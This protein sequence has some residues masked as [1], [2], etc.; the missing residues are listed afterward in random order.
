M[1]RERGHEIC[2]R[3]IPNDWDNALPVGN[4]RL[5]AMVFRQG[6]VLHIALNHYDCYYQVLPGL[7]KEPGQ[8]GQT[9]QD[10]A[11]MTETY[12]ELCRRADAA[13]ERGDTAYSHYVRTL[14]PNRGTGRPSYRG[15][16]YPPGGEVLLEMSGTVDTGHSC[17]KLRIEEAAVTLEAGNGA[18][19]VAARIWAARDRDGIVVELFQSQG[20]LWK[21]IR[22]TSPPVVGMPPGRSEYRRMRHGLCMRTFYARKENGDADILQEAALCVR[23]RER[24]SGC[25]GESGEN[26]ADDFIPFTDAGTSMTAVVSL[27]P[28][29]GNAER[30]AEKLAGEAGQA[31]LRHQAFWERFWVS[32]VHLPDAFLE[33]L[34]YLQLY[35]MECSCGRGSAWPEQACGLSGLWDIRRPNMW[36]SMWY[37]D[38][39]IQSAFW[40]WGSAGHPEFLKLFCDGYLA[41][42]PEIRAYTEKVYGVKGWALDY[43]HTLYHCIQPWCAQF[44]WQ[45][46]QYSQD[47]GFLREKAYP[48]FREQVVFFRWLSETDGQGIRHIRYDISPEQGPVTEDSVITISC[49]RRLLQMAEEA[50]KILDRSVEELE[51]YRRL[52]REL[53]PYPLA[54]DGNRY[55][56]S[57]LVQDSVFLRHP[58]MLMPLFP[59]E[60]KGVE[61]K[62]KLWENT[63]Q[64]AVGHTETGTFGMGWLAAAAAKLG[65]GRTALRLLYEKGLDYALHNNGLI[66]E[67]SE[68]F[69]NYCH[70]TKPSHFLPVMMEAAGGLANTVNLML[71]QTGEE[72]ELRIFPAVPDET[73]D[74]PERILQYHEDI[75]EAERVY[76]SWKDVSFSGLMAPGGFRVWAERRGGRTIYLKVESRFEAVLKLLLPEELAGEEQTLWEGRQA[77]PVEV[78]SSG[79][80]G[81]AE[82]VE[83]RSSG[84]GR[85]TEPVEV[86]RR[87]AEYRMKPGE[88]RCWGKNTASTPARNVASCHGQENREGAKAPGPDGEVLCHVAAGTRRRVFLGGDRHTAYFQAIDAFTCAYLLANEH[89][90]PRTP[91]VF[92]FGTGMAEKEYADAYP[93]QF[94]VSGQCVLYAAGPKSV[95]ICTYDQETGYGFLGTEGISDVD[96]GEPDALRRDFLEGRGQA[97]FALYL[98]KGKYDIL[99]ICGDEREASCTRVVLPG[100]GTAECTGKLEAGRFGC[101]V[102]PLVHRQDG[103]LRIGISTEEGYR[104]KLNAMF[105]NQ[106][107]VLSG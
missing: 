18:A 76:D 41:Y 103:M 44:L 30:E 34:W 22:L 43:P 49:I 83:V 1:E 66:Y 3:D 90:Y 35:L 68:R 91:Y 84:K 50:G 88:V 92:D 13:R 65:R 5:G 71:L 69:L 78:R 60:E 80:G 99:L 102:L 21:G 75:G 97:V 96:R 87:V 48:V 9:F 31:R 95:G 10:P 4:G 74:I 40:G 67:E 61:E 25:I 93:M 70:L 16:C 100:N 17:L 86:K 105:V 8:G 47:M 63:L 6:S 32:G 39:N 77:E 94:A 27:Q 15:V 7:N 59:A 23:E 2:F 57:R 38:V 62:R 55:K 14:H 45:Y 101:L 104:W 107:Y 24:I 106:E 72:G 28:G 53:P 20:G 81:Q 73:P 37:W 58:S 19:Q 12:E 89:R 51:E 29:F 46:Y 54:E 98:P 11:R 26:S 33:R 82:P 52:E 36:G 56:D 64:Y 79:K 42:E 85:Q